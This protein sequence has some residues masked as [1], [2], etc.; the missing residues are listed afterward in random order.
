M[1]HSVFLEWGGAAA[2]DEWMKQ[3]ISRR[4]F[5]NKVSILQTAAAATG[6][7][8]D[9]G[10]DGGWFWDTFFFLSYSTQMRMFTAGGGESWL[11]M[12]KWY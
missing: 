6:G 3:R 10:R 8:G 2:E 4:T 11:K 5:A 7:G 1:N 12:E 9:G